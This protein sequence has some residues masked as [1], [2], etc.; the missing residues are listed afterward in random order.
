M[1]PCLAQA[2]RLVVGLPFKHANFARKGSV[3]AAY[4][5]PALALILGLQEDPIRPAPWLVG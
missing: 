1:L 4:L 5:P 3:T 2:P